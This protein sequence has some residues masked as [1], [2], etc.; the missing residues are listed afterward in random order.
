MNE[1][2]I[3]KGIKLLCDGKYIYFRRFSITPQ[4]KHSTVQPSTIRKILQKLKKANKR[5][6]HQNFSNPRQYFQTVEPWN[7]LNYQQLVTEYL[8]GA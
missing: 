3:L 2:V 5:K 4:I 1:C 6:K 8:P 7:G